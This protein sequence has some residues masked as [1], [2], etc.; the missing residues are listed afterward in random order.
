M[1]HSGDACSLFG[2]R[3]RD[4]SPSRPQKQTSDASEKHPYLSAK[5]ISNVATEAMAVAQVERT[6]EEP[7]KSGHNIPIKATVARIEARMTSQDVML[8]ASERSPFAF[9][10]HPDTKRRL[11]G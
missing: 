2:V 9:L 11:S 8:V 5:S 7:Q 6:H 3:G 10:R 1:P 4:G